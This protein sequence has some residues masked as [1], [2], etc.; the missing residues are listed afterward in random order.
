[1]GEKIIKKG[2]IDDFGYLLDE[3]WQY[4]REMSGN[5]SNFKIDEIYRE[6]KKCGALGGKLLG[7]G[8]GGFMLFYI[9]ENKKK[10]FLKKNRK[11]LNIPFKFTDTGSE[12]IFNYN[13]DL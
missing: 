13:N 10:N 8:G 7:A 4:K 5:I 9:K 6:A 12:I 11:L 2:S 3:A 1:M